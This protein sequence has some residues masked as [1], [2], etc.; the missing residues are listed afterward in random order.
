MGT[1]AELAPEATFRC[2]T[3]EEEAR[4]ELRATQ[5]VAELVLPP[6]APRP[7]GMLSGG[8]VTAQVAHYN[9]DGPTREPSFLS[10]V[11]G[12]NPATEHMMAAADARE[13]L[14]QFRAQLAA[15]VA[16]TGCKGKLGGGTFVVIEM[17]GGLGSA[18]D[19][20]GSFALLAERI[21]QRLLTKAEVAAALGE[22]L[23]RWE[24]E[25]PTRMPPTKDIGNRYVAT[26]PAELLGLLDLFDDSARLYV[27][28]E[29]PAP[30]GGGGG[31]GGACGETSESVKPDWSLGVYLDASGRR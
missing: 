1:P 13:S 28:R 24:A 4:A 11:V 3:G 12:L 19:Y 22:H 25:A 21:G 10:I 7:L 16:A 14:A 6:D 18:N 23:E 17:P 30:S 5:H 31:G 26:L 15:Q 20:N 2:L 29:W 8:G 9:T 27:S